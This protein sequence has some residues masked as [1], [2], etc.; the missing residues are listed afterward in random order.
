M[1][2]VEL[3]TGGQTKKQE[4]KPAEPK[5]QGF[6]PVEEISI[7]EGWRQI[8]TSEWRGVGLLDVQE[9]LQ[10]EWG[11]QILIVEPGRD[12]GRLQAQYRRTMIFEPAE[13]QDAVSNWPENAALILAKRT[14]VGKIM[15]VK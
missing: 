1:G 6:Y 12:R 5:R 4:Q 14:F 13:F 2:F 11:R 10:Y 3:V 9:P 15:G 8:I 7:A